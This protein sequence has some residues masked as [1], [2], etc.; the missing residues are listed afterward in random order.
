VICFASR[1]CMINKEKDS[2]L[3]EV[4]ICLAEWLVIMGPPLGPVATVR[5]SPHLMYRTESEF[6]ADLGDDVVVGL[7]LQSSFSQW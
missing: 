7:G 4:A 3:A 5:L 2:F 1:I 6:D